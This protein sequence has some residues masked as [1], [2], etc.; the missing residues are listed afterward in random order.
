MV[1]D[2]ERRLYLGK[3]VLALEDHPFIPGRALQGTSLGWAPSQP[4]S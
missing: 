4:L 2:S 1:T 3:Y